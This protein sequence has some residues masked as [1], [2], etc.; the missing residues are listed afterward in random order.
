MTTPKTET[1]PEIPTWEE[2]RKRINSPEYLNDRRIRLIRVLVYEGSGAMVAACI[3]KSLPVGRRELH[4]YTISVYQDEIEDLGPL[5]PPHSPP[6][7]P[8]EEIDLLAAKVASLPRPPLTFE[9][10][11]GEDPDPWSAEEVK[12]GLAAIEARD[13]LI[14]TLL[15]KL[16]R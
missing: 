7:T 16:S 3:A 2:I 6:V 15:S 5:N 4:G 14:R 1:A 10:E 11:D 9:P 13:N 8:Q 12:Q